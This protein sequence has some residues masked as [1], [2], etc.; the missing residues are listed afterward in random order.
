MRR[1]WT[2]AVLTCIICS[3]ASCRPKGVLSSGQMEDLFVDLHRAEGIIYVNGYMNGHD[4]IVRLT[5][6]SILAAHGVTRAQ[7]D[8]SLVWYTD[9]PMMFNKI[10]PHVMERLET[11]QKE[12]RRNNEEAIQREKEEMMQK[13][14]QQSASPPPDSERLLKMK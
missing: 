10:Y 9:N 11:M 7:F 4:S 8:S 5:Y 12:E 13:Q 14:G 2:I 1:I 6:D 3:L